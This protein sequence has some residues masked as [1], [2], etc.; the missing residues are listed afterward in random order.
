MNKLSILAIALL[1]STSSL[2]QRKPEHQMDKTL[3]TNKVGEHL[4]KKAMTPMDLWELG[5]VSAE[6]LTPDGQTLIYGVSNYSLE[7]NKSEKNLFTVNIST[8]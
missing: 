8:G 6:G 3:I 7:S 5:R 2:A 4:A 1:L